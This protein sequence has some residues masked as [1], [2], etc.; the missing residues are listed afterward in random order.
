MGTRNLTFGG[1][2]RESQPYTAGLSS[3]FPGSCTTH[4]TFEIDG[5]VKHSESHLGEE[6]ISPCGTTNRTS[7]HIKPHLGHNVPHLWRLK[8]LNELN[9]LWGRWFVGLFSV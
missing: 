8:S 7:E 9:F 2:L 1:G 5:A 3:L 4:L 6:W